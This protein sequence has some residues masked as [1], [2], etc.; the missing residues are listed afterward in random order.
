MEAALGIRPEVQIFGNDY[1]TPDGTCI[2]DYVHVSDL[3]AGHVAALD[4]IR[5]SGASLTVNLGSETGCS[6]TD[7]IETAR[8]VTGRPIPAR[9]VGRRPGDPAKLYASSA[10]AREIL[11]WKA[12]YSDMETLIATSWK[13]YKGISTS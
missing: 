6:V 1:D 5:A 9:V 7:V 10:R 11:G 12:R 13:V 2:R 8:K 3:A 4:Y